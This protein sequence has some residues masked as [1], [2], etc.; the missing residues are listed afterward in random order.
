M[1]I[2]ALV[3]PLLAPMPSSGPVPVPALVLSAD[4]P[5]ASEV[6]AEIDHS[7]R[8][9]R[10]RQDRASG[11][12]ENTLG[13]AWTV[14]AL[15]DS[16][17][18]Y[19][20]GDGPFLDDAIAYLLA[21][22]EEGG[23]LST[24]D[25]PDTLAVARLAL[26]AFDGPA[27]KGARERLEAL[28]GEARQSWP[29]PRYTDEF[30]SAEIGSKIAETFLARRAPDGS[31]DGPR[32]S[33][34]ET[35]QLTWELTRAWRALDSASGDAPASEPA[36]S[37]ASAT[38]LPPF[39]P[40]DRERTESA[41]A[42]GAAFLAS[43]ANNGR[44][45]AGDRMDPGITAMVLGAMLCATERSEDAEKAI[46]GGLAWLR[47]LQRPDGSIHD[48]QLANYVTSAAILALVRAGNEEDA[49]RI[50]KARDFLVGLQADEGEGY[51][52]SDRYYGGVG[53][54]GDERPDLSNLQMALEAMNASGLA[55]DDPAFDKAIRF[56][57]RAQNRSESNDLV[58]TTEGTT[59]VPGD[60]GGAG[61]APGES[62]AGFVELADGTKVPRSY[63]SM[64][65][66]LLKGYLFA[67]L[68]KEDPR[69][70]A[71]WE[72]LKANYT[73]DVNPGFGA[74]ADPQAA[75]QGL[76][77][78]FYTMARALDLY[79]AER[80]TDASGAEHPWRAE[81]SGRLIAMQR[82][83][84]SWLNANSPRWWEGNPVLA[85][86]YAMLALDAAR[87]TR[88]QSPR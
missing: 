31:W 29:W 9:L 43:A 23:D 28:L 14:A 86:A 82:A 44:W 32:G 56:L 2:L 4:G 10:A 50:A 49:P 47:S 62:K 20:P 48:G 59:I 18:R 83:D 68:D 88:A 21:Q 36:G 27:A 60:D 81:L 87:P 78:Y 8:W 54:G 71:A 80:I 76:F 63:G 16:P 64:T 3:A 40:A 42:R 79:G 33:V 55:A 39:T 45:G 46:E 65:Y 11:A 17:R 75:Y 77:Y 58:L 22:M 84:G 41:L 15:A 38:P 69:V 72:W 6:K 19:R 61:Y 70:V 24:T 5:T 66:A 85:T 26:G 13:T 35:A 67:G 73:L 53:Y 1:K 52:E 7:I 37:A 30:A 51:D 74:T 34:V 25:Q 12:Y 57:Q